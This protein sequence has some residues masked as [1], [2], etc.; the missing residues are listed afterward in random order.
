MKRLAALR[1]VLS[2]LLNRR[3]EADTISDDVSGSTR[4]IGLGAILNALDWDHAREEVDRESR[5]RI[6]LIGGVGAGKTTLLTM[7]RGFDVPG[8]EP[9][10]EAAG[11][12]VIEDMGLFVVVDIP[13]QGPNGYFSEGDPAWLAL[14]GADLIVWVLDGAAGLRPWEYEWICRVRA[15]GKSMAVILNKMDQVREREATDRLGRMLAY[16]VIPIAAYDGTNVVNR[17]LPHMVDVCP[18]LTTALGREVPAWRRVAAQRVTRRAVAVSGLVG[19]EPVPLLDIPFQVLIQLRLVLRLAAIYGEPVGD[20]YSRELLATIASGA[21][22]RYLGQQLSKVIPLVGWIASGGL[23]A[24]GTWAIGRIA[25]EYF[26]NGRRVRRLP[27]ID[28]EQQ[29]NRCSARR[30]RAEFRSWSRIFSRL[31]ARLSRK[32]ERNGPGDR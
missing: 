29:T 2:D 19:V 23:A 4:G 22:M 32:G 7:L 10:D 21:A 15:S 16:A 1:G 8:R 26:E 27:R 20:R 24:G 28:S 11:G 9:E 14:Q 17:L 12:P 18:S 13:A 31:K 3:G 5:A 25:M 6:A 30:M